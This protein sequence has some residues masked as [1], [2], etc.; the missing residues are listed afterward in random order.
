VAFTAFTGKSGSISTL[1]RVALLTVTAATPSNPPRLA[2]I[3]A[4]PAPAD[5]T[6]PL[7]AA[8]FTPA[9]AEAE[10]SHSA[11]AVTSFVILPSAVL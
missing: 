5:R 8:L 1:W 9:T 11:S 2:V 10:V 3:F 6:N 4:V 7:L